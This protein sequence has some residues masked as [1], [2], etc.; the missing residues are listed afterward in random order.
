MTI[1]TAACSVSYSA[2]QNIVFKAK[3]L[4]R[5]VMHRIDRKKLLIFTCVCLIFVAFDVVSFATHASPRSDKEGESVKL[6]T[7]GRGDSFG[8]GELLAAAE[9][10]EGAA[11]A[12]AAAAANAK[13]YG[14]RKTSGSEA[15]SLGLRKGTPGE[16]PGRGAAR[17]G[18]V[19]RATR[20]VC[21]SEMCEVMAVPRHLFANLLDDLGSVQRRLEEQ[22]T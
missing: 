6:L 3:G 21:V 17:G 22:V 15:L 10:E 16:G 14:S 19:P 20:A 7:I 11:I 1:A 2:L 13:L 4:E 9:A 8:G 12:T 5:K 18:G